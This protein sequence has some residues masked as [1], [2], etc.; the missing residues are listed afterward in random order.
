MQKKQKH[1]VVMADHYIYIVDKDEL[2]FNLNKIR[3][4]NA[5]CNCG[6]ELKSFMAYWDL[7]HTSD[8]RLYSITTFHE[9][10]I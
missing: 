8:G 4:Q 2:R 7:F 3:H 9:S 10:D 5:H 6:Q 1:P